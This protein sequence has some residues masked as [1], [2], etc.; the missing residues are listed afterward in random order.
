MEAQIQHLTIL[1]SEQKSSFEVKESHW[2]R[3]RLDYETRISQ[4][5]TSLNNAKAEKTT[6]EKEMGEKCKELQQ[7]IEDA[8]M[9]KEKA[10]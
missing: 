4:I 3:I 7:K 2:E 5:Q 9:E 1:L 8:R 6:V 10:Y